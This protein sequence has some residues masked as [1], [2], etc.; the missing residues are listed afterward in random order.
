[1]AKTPLSL[2]DNPRIKGRPEG[3]T[4]TITDI[5]PSNGAGFLV[6]YL[7]DINT[8]PALPS[9]PAAEGMDIDNDGKIVG[10]S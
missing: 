9:R 3:F 2:T 8:M 1:M 4:I 10:L 6:A 5:R 7:E